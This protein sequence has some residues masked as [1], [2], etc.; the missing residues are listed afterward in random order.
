MLSKSNDR[1]H[2]VDEFTC[3]TLV[4]LIKPLPYGTFIETKTKWLKVDFYRKTLG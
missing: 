1:V 4:A 2:A 3:A